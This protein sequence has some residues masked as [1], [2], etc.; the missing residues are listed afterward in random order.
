MKN[1]QAHLNTMNTLL[2]AYQGR[3]MQEYERLK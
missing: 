1:L 3:Y 2:Q